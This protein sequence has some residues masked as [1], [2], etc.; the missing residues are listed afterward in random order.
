VHQMMDL[1]RQNHRPRRQ[2]ALR[3]DDESSTTLRPPHHQPAWWSTTSRGLSA[4][5]LLQRDL[6]KGEGLE[7]DRPPRAVAR[8]LERSH[9]V[10]SRSAV[11]VLKDVLPDLPVTMVVKDREAPPQRRRG[12]AGVHTAT[13]ARRASARSR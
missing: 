2:A 3:R 7:G 8:R 12:G 11:L 9:P 6:T 4:D 13:S 5:W 10:C 1:Q